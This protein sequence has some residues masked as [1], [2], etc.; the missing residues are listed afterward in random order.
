MPMCT[1]VCPKQVP[2]WALVYART[3][4]EK[5]EKVGLLGQ[6]FCGMVKA[7]KVRLPD[8]C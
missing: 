2:I 3:V 6:V 4:P 8:L 1:V 5:R 7:K